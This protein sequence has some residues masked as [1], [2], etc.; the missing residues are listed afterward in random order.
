M[1][2]EIIQ[3]ELSVK[4][5][6]PNG[7]HVVIMENVATV[8]RKWSALGRKQK[9]DLVESLSRLIVEQFE[10]SLMLPHSSAVIRVKWE[11]EETDFIEQF[12]LNVVDWN[13]F[14]MGCKAIQAVIKTAVTYIG[15]ILHDNNDW[16][17]WGSHS[18]MVEYADGIDHLNACSLPMRYCGIELIGVDWMP[19]TMLLLAKKGGVHTKNGWLTV[20]NRDSTVLLFNLALPGKGEE[21][22]GNDND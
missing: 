18:Q 2:T 15:P 7:E 16:G 6:K 8:D 3:I 14:S 12:G 13:N 22:D 4:G 11:P 5:P 20:K 10:E 9:V 21:T 1:K 17:I 19:E